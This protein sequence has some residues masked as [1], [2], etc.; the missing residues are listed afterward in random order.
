MHTVYALYSQNFKKIY[1][2]CTSDIEKRLVS[3]NLLATKGW[4]IRFRPWILIYSEVFQSKTDALK[5]ERE[6]K[7]AKGRD[8]IWNL[9]HNRQQK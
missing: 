5:R 6:L 3:H 2:G 1:I 7:S 9:I 8:F 4:T